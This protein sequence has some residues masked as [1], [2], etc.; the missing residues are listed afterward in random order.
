VHISKVRSGYK[1]THCILSNIHTATLDKWEPDLVKMMCK[2]GNE[3]VNYIYEANI[4][5]N[6]KKPDSDT[7]R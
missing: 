5:E 2:I 7:Q 3:R 1:H 4:P 6:V